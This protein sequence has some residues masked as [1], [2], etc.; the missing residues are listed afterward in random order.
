MAGTTIPSVLHVVTPVNRQFYYTRHCAS[1][2]RL[3]NIIPYNLP[4]WQRVAWSELLL[5]A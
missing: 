3:I 2:T 5:L 1:V 4:R